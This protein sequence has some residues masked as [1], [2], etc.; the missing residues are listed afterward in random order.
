MDSLVQQLQQRF[1][2]P[3]H[4][5]NERPQRHVLFHRYPSLTFATRLE[6]SLLLGTLCNLLSSLLLSL[7]RRVFG[8]MFLLHPVRL[9]FLREGFDGFRR[10][11]CRSGEYCSSRHDG[12]M[13]TT[14]RLTVPFYAQRPSVPLVLLTCFLLDA[15]AFLI[16]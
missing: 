1:T 4:V 6:G 5:S 12:R 11:F 14:R 9:V 2:S 3:P 7:G 13:N 15:N 16:P 8:K 10:C